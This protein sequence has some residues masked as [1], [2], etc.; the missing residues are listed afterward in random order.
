MKHS[1]ALG[2]VARTSAEGRPQQV[3]GG[4]AGIAFDALVFEV[5]GVSER[6]GPAS[7]RTDAATAIDDTIINEARK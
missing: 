5:G 6:C 1:P 4:D 7:G 2:S 3:G